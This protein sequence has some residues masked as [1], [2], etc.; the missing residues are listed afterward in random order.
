MALEYGSILAGGG[1]AVIGFYSH[2][3]EAELYYLRTDV[4]GA[5]RW[6]KTNDKK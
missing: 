2:P 4:G 5:Y 6:E 1:G 3:L